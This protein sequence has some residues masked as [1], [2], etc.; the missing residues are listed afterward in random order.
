MRFDDRVTGNLLYA[1]QAKSDSFEIDPAGRIN[2]KQIAAVVADLK[3][4]LT[5]LLP[6]IQNST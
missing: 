1:K 6:L 2:V 4:S 5:A 3:E